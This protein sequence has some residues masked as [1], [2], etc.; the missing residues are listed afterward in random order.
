VFPW[1]DAVMIHADRVFMLV[2]LIATAMLAI[3]TARR[4]DFAREVP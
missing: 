2:L 1:L 4:D 3:K